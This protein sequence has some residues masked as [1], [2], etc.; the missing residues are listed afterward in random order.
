M[1]DIDASSFIEQQV[2]AIKDT[3]GEEKALVAVS[4][5]V[6]S[7]VSALLTHK[8]I[9]LNLICVFIDDN[10]MRLGETEQV[11]TILSKEPIGLPVKVVNER[12]RFMSALEGLSDAEEKRKAFR[13]TFYETLRSIAE[14]ENCQFLVQ[15]TIRTDVEETQRGIKTQ[16]NVL[17]P[18]G[19]NPLDKFGFSVIEPLKSLYKSQVR[20]VA[21][22]LGVSPL[23]SERQ[24]FPGPGLSIR[25]VGEITPKK[26]DELKKANFI[27]EQAF[28]PHNP[29]QFF[30]AIFSGEQNRDLKVL[31][32]EA[33][34]IT[35]I[36]QRFIKAGILSEKATGI[37]DSGR[38]YGSIITLALEDASDN[39]L[40]PD[41]DNLGSVL[42]YLKDNYPEATRLIYLVDEKDGAGYN[43]VMRAVKT[44]D[45]LKAESMRIP[46][47]TLSETASKI[48]E[49]CTGVTK[50]YYDVTPKPPA[51]IEYE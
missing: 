1:A 4:G 44:K 31:R 18:V 50:V 49:S 20:I 19:I 11:K 41:Y 12:Q 16:H 27:V 36:D 45:F 29:S 47:I 25:V 43:I 24:P 5:G 21:R 30:A 32:R 9:G 26:L 10:F 28:E 22:Y 2:Y 35:G 39:V 38:V 51:T 13:K 3:L 23:V 17:E 48:L 14:D 40:R 37:I 34:N 33:S 8:A 42:A 7:T 6:D 46:W 15:G